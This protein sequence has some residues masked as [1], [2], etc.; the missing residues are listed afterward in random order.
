MGREQKDPLLC[1]GVAHWVD[2]E[3]PLAEAIL[4]VL[5]EDETRA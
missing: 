5:G 2:L 4:K 3:P 1:L